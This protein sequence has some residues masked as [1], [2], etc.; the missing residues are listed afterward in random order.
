MHSSWGIQ[1]GPALTSLWAQEQVKPQEGPFSAGEG[2]PKARPAACPHPQAPG[3]GLL[4]RSKVGGAEWREGRQCCCHRSAR[5][6]APQSLCTPPSRSTD[7]AMAMTLC[8]APTTLLIRQPLCSHPLSCS[9]TAPKA[10]TLLSQSLCDCCSLCLECSSRTSSRL[11]SS[12]PS[13]FLRR[14]LGKLSL[15]ILQQITSPPQHLL[16]ALSCFS[17]QPPCEMCIFCL[18]NL[19]AVSST[20]HTRPG[21]ERSVLFMDVSAPGSTL[22]ARSDKYL[23]NECRNEWGQVGRGCPH[24]S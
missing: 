3:R 15:S 7:V 20:I 9:H 17:P 18:R 16:S 6:S 13:G 12:P 21:A 8:A 14:C 19:T 2:L 22:P 23:L 24:P 11:I 10:G 5:C 4:S 1:Q